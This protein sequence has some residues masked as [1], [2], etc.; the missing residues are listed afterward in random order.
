M[1][2]R[3]Q[4]S[5]HLPS[6]PRV[7]SSGYQ[8]VVIREKRTR[9]SFHFVSP[10]C[11]PLHPD[12]IETL[13]KFTPREREVLYSNVKY[14]TGKDL[15]FVR[16]PGGEIMWP[17]SACMYATTPARIFCRPVGAIGRRYSCRVCILDVRT[18]RSIRRLISLADDLG[19]CGDRVTHGVRQCR[20]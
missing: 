20:W 12:W 6:E 19:H 3:R 7:A 13:N 8:V 11:V 5:L 15:S 1:C 16:S 2:S 4:E 9:K 14:L 18:R 10:D 17:R